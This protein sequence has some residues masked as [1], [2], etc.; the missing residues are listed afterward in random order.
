[1]WT[2]SLSE[3]EKYDR[4]ITARW[5]DDTN[6][7]LVFTGLFSATVA[8][9]VIEGYK[10]LNVDPGGQTVALLG[11]ISQQLSGISDGTGLPPSSPPDSSPPN[12][13][14]AIRIN[15][16][17]LLSL[18][19]SITCALLA[20]LIQQWARRYMTLSYLHDMPHERARV[21]TY[22][23][24]GMEY[25]RMRRAI[26]TVPMLLHIS[27]FLFFAGLVDFFL[28][29][30]DTVGWVFVGWVG[31]F[32]SVYIAMTVIP[33]V[34]LNC[35]YR[36][37]FSGSL[38][39]ILQILSIAALVLTDAL[40]LSLHAFLL[41][42]WGR[43]YRGAS[44]SVGTLAQREKLVKQITAHKHRFSQG[45]QRCVVSSA[46]D[47]PSL[48][49]REALI[50]TLTKLDEDQEVEDFIARIP[51]FFDSRIVSEAPIT[52]LGLMRSPP[53]GGDSVLA[54]RLR[55][56]L[57]TCLSTTSGLDP[58]VRKSRLHV[59]LTAMWY[60]AKAYNQTEGVPMSKYFRMLFT[61]Q[62]EINLLLADDDL[63]TK[64]L[65]LCMGSL[66][67]SRIMEEIG[68]HSGDP[69]VSDGELVFL[70]KALGP[71]W[72]LD[73]VEHKP[74][75]LT[76]LDSM[77]G[78]LEKIAREQIPEGETLGPEVLDTM[79]ILAE[80]VL[81]CISSPSA[82]S[83][84]VNLSILERARETLKRCLS[85]S[86]AF[87]ADTQLDGLMK[88]EALE[89]MLKMLKDLDTHLAQY[90][91]SHPQPQSDPNSPPNTHTPAPVE[92][93]QST[94]NEDGYSL[95][96]NQDSHEPLQRGPN[97]EEGIQQSVDS[98]ISASPAVNKQALTSTLAELSEDDEFESFVAR[99]PS[100]IGSHVLSNI[101][102][103]L[104]LMAPSGRGDSAF[105]L[106]LHSF[107]KTSLPGESALGPDVRKRRLHVCL[108]AV[109]SYIKAYNESDPQE[110]PI[111][112]HFL[113]LFA[114]P[115]DM[116][117]LL[118]DDDGRTRVMALCIRSLLAA[119]VV[120]DVRHRIDNPPVSEAELDL[121]KRALGPFWRPDLHLDNHGPIELANLMAM[122]DGLEKVA[123]QES[124]PVG[125]L[126]PE[127]SE[128]LDI[129]A[130]SVLDNLPEDLPP[131][132]WGSTASA[133]GH[134]YEALRWFLSYFGHLS[135]DT[136]LGGPMMRSAWMNSLVGRLNEL[137]TKLARPTSPYPLSR[138]QTP[139]ARA[140]S[141]IDDMQSMV[142]S[143]VLTSEGHPSRPTTHEGFALDRQYMP[144]PEPTLYT[145]QEYSQISV[146]LRY[147]PY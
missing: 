141:P 46:I 140:Q 19:I 16:L 5:N 22:L 56:L 138:S 64:V 132:P 75:E 94:T 12:L 51:G 60:Y 88:S 45:L 73:L 147:Q 10:Q 81:D 96:A 74:T 33:N 133:I 89:S 3:F 52:M 115:S 142:E 92:G 127:G 15:I 41:H 47:A 109:Y 106:R 7:V 111:P 145:G 67:V 119:K 84:G 137:S 8:A 61:N 48:V 82:E 58:S 25:F 112:E 85:L 95:Q 26:E 97:A 122:V 130:E 83:H 38:W 104:D 9:F 6:G 146:P 116:D 24:T 136:Y 49:D 31:I 1:M 53:S 23:F 54:A 105:A 34:F 69:Q 72:R 121:L 135:A 100:F 123:H 66:L 18:A 87:G 70:K 102:T 62:N 2:L 11:Q 117:H 125:N 44:A 99:V 80:D 134:S 63:Q 32:A 139:Q 55:G 144:M 59:C 21:R 143:V 20:T 36:T 30:N 35:P 128:T 120:E 27:V 40:A 131:E 90:T 91:A 28:L 108:S 14:A 68:D 101:S 78:E 13:A 17:W 39:R 29:F 4:E 110:R 57:K 71:L 76:N 65:V 93:I 79:N 107:F 126:G 77:V 124:S 43:I 103:M 98:P 114:D 37:P 42:I 129:L 50:W 113:T 118:V 86:K